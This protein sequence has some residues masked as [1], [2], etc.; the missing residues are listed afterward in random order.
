[1]AST[2]MMC[3]IPS[4]SLNRQYDASVVYAS[5][6]PSVMYQIIRLAIVFVIYVKFV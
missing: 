1:M 6:V 5:T 3:T 4:L 2:A